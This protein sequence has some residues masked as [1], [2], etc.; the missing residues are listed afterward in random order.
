MIS[1]VCEETIHTSGFSFGVVSGELV[2]QQLLLLVIMKVIYVKLKVLF[3][4]AIDHLRLSIRLEVVLSRKL[5]LD[6]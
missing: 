4:C 5:S 3:H 1:I 6:S 2:H